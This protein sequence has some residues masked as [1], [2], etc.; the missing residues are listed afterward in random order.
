MPAGR[1]QRIDED[2]KTVYIV[3]NGRTLAAPLSEVETRARIPSARVWFDLVRDG[4]TETAA[5]VRLRTGTRT[6]RRHRRFG[7][8]TG[9]ARPGA[10]VQTAASRNYGVDV[11]T[12][13]FRVAEAWLDALRRQDI[14]GATSLYLPEATI[15]TESGAAVGHARIRAALDRLPLVDV[16]EDP[17]EISGVDRYVRIECQVGEEDH[18]T[19]LVTDRG[20]IAE[21]WIDIEPDE[22]LDG[23]DQSDD[24]HATEVVRRGQVPDRAVDYATEKLSHLAD[25]T[26]QPLRSTRVKL[27]K[28][29]NP[30]FDRPA[31]AEA[32]LEFEHSMVRARGNAETFLEAI[33][34]V[35]ARLGARIEHQRDRQRHQPTRLEPLPG[36]W[37]HGNLARPTT[38]FFDRPVDER[39][40]VRH[41]SF[42][43]DDMTVDEAAWDMALLDY[44]F[45]LFVDAATDQDSL[46]EQGEDGALILHRLG[47]AEAIPPSTVNEVQPAKTSPPDLAVSEAIGLLDASGEHLQFFINRVTGRG[48]V[49]YRRFDGHYGLITPADEDGDHPGNDGI[50]DRGDR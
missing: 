37:R 49:V 41:K 28:A 47:D 36:T 32:S 12:Q 17:V 26:G 3:R 19:Y 48:N 38:P 35:V 43:P 27:T 14:D 13:P 24:G 5:G 1:V 46:L 23:D 21:Q 45:F 20:S 15:H 31:M 18:V 34:L 9:A 6:N 39:E 42:A 33:D 29:E 11:T 44:D 25:H 7:D 8:L 50:D 4:G 22:P 40:I 30:A 16:E 2:K 10:K